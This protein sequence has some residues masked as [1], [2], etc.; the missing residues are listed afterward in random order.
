M[1]KFVTSVLGRTRCTPVILRGTFKTVERRW[2]ST[3]AAKPLR[4]TG[5][6]DFHMENGA[7]MVPFAGYD[8][9]LTYSGVGQVESHKHVRSSV[10]LFDVGHMVQHYFRGPGATDFLEWLTPSSLE[11]LVPNSSTLSVLLL[12]NGGILD[13]TV[14][15]KHSPEQYY[16]VTNAGRRDEDLSWFE[17]KIK[18]WNASHSN[19][20]QHEVLENWGLVALQGPK[21]ADYLQGFVEASGKNPYDL[22]RLTFGKC[23]TLNIAGT[24][25][26][27]ARGGYTGE[28]GFEISLP[29][30]ETVDWTRKI[31]KFPVQ[32]CGLAARDSLRLEA[33]LCLYG[34]DLDETTSPVEAGLSWVIGKDRRT[35]GS[36]RANFIGA[37]VVIGQLNDGVKR[38]RVGF[39]VEGPPARE[40]A[41]L[42]HSGEQV[43]KITSGIPSPTLE[44]NIAMGYVATQHSKRGTELEVEVRGKRRKAT[45]SKMPFVPTRYW[46]GEGVTTQ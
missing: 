15:T 40:G 29:P 27:V 12:P 19:Q 34:S 37:D 44:K 22:K 16:V 41:L 26:H 21:A 6:Y 38:K 8:M 10:G 23:A 4:R 32:L 7:K 14:I 17:A 42:Y 1:S 24:E 20:V 33:G 36:D 11:S 13:D 3:D 39:M 35:L 2:A 5:L 18:E 9:P 31:H 45:V 28:D 25:V 46:R 43:G 30:S